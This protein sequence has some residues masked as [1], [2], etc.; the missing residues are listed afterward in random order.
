VAVTT[1][2]VL[3]TRIKISSLGALLRVLDAIIS[4][5]LSGLKKL[6]DMSIPSSKYVQMHVEPVQS[7]LTTGRLLPSLAVKYGF[8][9]VEE[10]KTKAQKKFS[11][12]ETG[13]LDKPSTR[14]LLV[15]VSHS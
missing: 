10:F 5:I 14:L 3:P 2:F 13:I 8:D 9:S 15:N 1:L 7:M 11:L 12:L 6:M 4:S